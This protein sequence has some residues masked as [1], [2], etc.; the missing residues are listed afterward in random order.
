MN[1]TV[2]CSSRVVDQVEEVVVVIGVFKYCPNYIRSKE[3]CQQFFPSTNSLISYLALHPGYWQ[4]CSFLVFRSASKQ[5]MQTP[6]MHGDG[7]HPSWKK[8][9]QLVHRLQPK[10]GSFSDGL[11]WSYSR[12]CIFPGT[13]LGSNIFM[14]RHLDLSVKVS[15]RLSRS[16]SGGKF[17]E[18]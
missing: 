17:S 12:C 2:R 7:M 14:N 8:S 6:C 18:P 5:N 4:L 10:E 13:R 1:T 16:S 15:Q 3:L 11:Y 9:S